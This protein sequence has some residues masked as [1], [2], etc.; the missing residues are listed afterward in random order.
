[1]TK[2]CRFV[3]L[4]TA[5]VG[6][7]FVMVGCGSTGPSQAAAPD[8]SPATTAAPVKAAPQSLLDITG[9]GEKSSNTFKAG[10]D[11]D[12]TWSAQ[13]TSG[14]GAYFSATAYDASTK[15]PV[16]MIGNVQVPGG[17]T[18]QDVSHQHGGGTYYLQVSG[19]NCTWHVTVTG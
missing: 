8:K 5:L 17:G 9:D 12:V 15:L 14:Y 2:L 13:D 18:K 3:T 10:G 4:T 6:M 1:M 19:A 7:V 11:F 16:A